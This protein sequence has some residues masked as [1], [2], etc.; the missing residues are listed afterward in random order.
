M[1]KAC[2]CWGSRRNYTPVTGVWRNVTF[3]WRNVTLFFFFK[4]SVVHFSFSQHC[5]I[6]DL[7]AGWTP[8]NFSVVFFRIDCFTLHSAA[9]FSSVYTVS[10]FYFLSTMNNIVL[11]TSPIWF[12]VPLSNIPAVFPG[13]CSLWLQW[14]QLVLVSR[15]L[16]TPISEHRSQHRVLLATDFHLNSDNSLITDLQIYFSS[17]ENTHLLEGFIKTVFS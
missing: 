7:N 16:L 5:I 6:E 14:L 2:L 10:T 1:P 12:P 9:N 13:F 15:A 8:Q 11:I 17:W 4:F 3:L